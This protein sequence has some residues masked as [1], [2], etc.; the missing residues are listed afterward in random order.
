VKLCYSSTEMSAGRVNRI[1]L[2]LALTLLLILSALK[3]LPPPKTRARRI[4][5][6]NHVASITITL[7]GTNALP[8]PSSI[9]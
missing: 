4:H 9:K 2:T 3:P 5:A 1:L 6:V 7:P 8:F